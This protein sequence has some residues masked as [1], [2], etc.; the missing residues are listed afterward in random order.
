MADAH[1][2]A[3][4][5]RWTRLSAAAAAIAL[6]TVAFTG[7]GGASVRHGAHQAKSGG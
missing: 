5:R 2:H 1:R 4:P 6:V 7:L 3:T